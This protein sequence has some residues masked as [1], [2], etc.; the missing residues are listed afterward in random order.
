MKNFFWDVYSKDLN[1][2]VL[3]ECK[4]HIAKFTKNSDLR[5]I[6][7]LNFVID[8]R[9]EWNAIE[10]ERYNHVEDQIIKLKPASEYIVSLV[11][12]RFYEYDI[13]LESRVYYGDRGN[14]IRIYKEN[15]QDKYKPILIMD[16]QVD[17]SSEY[18]QENIVDKCCS[19]LIVKEYIDS[20]PLRKKSEEIKDLE[21]VLNSFLKSSLPG[22]MMMRISDVEHHL[23][24]ILFSKLLIC[25]KVLNKS[26][27]KIKNN[28]I[29]TD[30]KNIIN[31]L[32]NFIQK[33]WECDGRLSLCAI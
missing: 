22:G 30:I 20:L 25:F 2:E 6:D 28:K 33:K 13:E 32:D 8:Y 21:R 31:F 17:I 12:E 26:H 5:E 16:K 24:P 14:F 19:L 3:L 15:P 7:W 27:P 1:E 9:Y 18:T 11:S 10:G 23:D 29:I 4:E